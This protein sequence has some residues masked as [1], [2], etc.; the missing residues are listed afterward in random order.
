MTVRFHPGEVLPASLA[1]LALALALPPSPWA[2]AVLAGTSLTAL[3]Q[4]RIPWR[5][6]TAA[7]SAVAAFASLSALPLAWNA[8]FRLADARLWSPPLRSFAAGSALLLLGLSAQM[9]DLLHLGRR[10]RMPPLWIDLVFLLYRF[11]MTALEVSASMAQAMSARAPRAGWRRQ[12][13]AAA[14][15]S[16]SLLLRILARARRTELALAARGAGG[17]IVPPAPAK[18]FSRLNVV[19][20]LGGP[21]AVACAALFGGGR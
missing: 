12:V 4:V 11:A 14:W 1:W 3:A 8:S 5:R 17:F 21:M 7:L 10:L 13:R 15:L 16:A 2:A 18:S 19:R 6:W 20:L 9:L